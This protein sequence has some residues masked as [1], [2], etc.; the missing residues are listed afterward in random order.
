MAKPTFAGA[1]KQLISIVGE[2]GDKTPFNLE[3]GDGNE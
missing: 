2:N 1:E 3:D